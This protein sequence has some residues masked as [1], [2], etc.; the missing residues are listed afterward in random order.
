[1]IR[2]LDKSERQTGLAFAVVLAV[3]GLAM[4]AIA[5]NGIMAAHGSTLEVETEVG[6]G[7]RFFFSLPR[8]RSS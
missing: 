8:A 5:G 4:A 2:S 7:S 1:M 3:A 6:V